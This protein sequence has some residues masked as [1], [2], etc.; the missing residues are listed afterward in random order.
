MSSSQTDRLA[1]GILLAVALVWTAAA[2]WLLPGGEQA[3]QIGPRGFPLGLGILLIVLSVFLLGGSYAPA[4]AAGEADEGR[5][6]AIDR[7]TERWALFATFGFLAVYVLLLD[8]FG[9]LIATIAATAAFLVIALDKRSPRLIAG[10]S[11]ILAFAIWLILGK[12][13]GVYLP[14]GSIIDWF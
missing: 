2:Y 4:E 5:G 12:A 11:L 9:F 13:M 10:I 8:L 6:P 3:G 7:R 1:G 14:R